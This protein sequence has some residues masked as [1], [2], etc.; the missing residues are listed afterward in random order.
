M[1]VVNAAP[2]SEKEKYQYDCS[3]LKAASGYAGPRHQH[4]TRR[5]QAQRQY[6]QAKSE[7]GGAKQKTR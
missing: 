4:K 7:P 1:N 2:A 5:G 3:D 6:I